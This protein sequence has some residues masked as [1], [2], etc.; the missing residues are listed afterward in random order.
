MTPT[1]R[2]EQNQSLIGYVYQQSFTA[3]ESE[4]E[5]LISEGR[6]GLWKACITFNEDWGVQFT[7]YAYPVIRNR[8][9]SY[10]NKYVVKH[11]NVISLD[12]VISDDGEGHTLCLYEAVGKD[13][14]VELKLLVKSCLARLCPVH[15]QII[16]LLMQGYTQDEIASSVHL[17]QSTVCR[18]LKRFKNIIMEEMN[19]A[20]EI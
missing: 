16:E 10:I 6:L 18:C 19:N 17:S 20:P 5:D 1:E 11:Q 12:S 7:T 8:M 3:W 14:S 13:D 2:F 4:H 9:L 15:R